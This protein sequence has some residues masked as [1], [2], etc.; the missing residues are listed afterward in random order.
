MK[1]RIEVKDNTLVLNG[2]PAVA[3]H[4]VIY[5]GENY[6]MIAAE[7]PD[8]K[9]LGPVPWTMLRCYECTVRPDRTF[10]LNDLVK[11]CEKLGGNIECNVIGKEGIVYRWER[12]S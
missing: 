12:C 11:E 9:L 3:D 8:F 7:R 2:F 4:I 5:I 10:V 1:N 6:G